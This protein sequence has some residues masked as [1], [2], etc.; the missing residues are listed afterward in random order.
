M[1]IVQ[2][3]R[4]FYYDKGSRVRSAGGHCFIHCVCMS[5]GVWEAWSFRCGGHSFELKEDGTKK[6]GML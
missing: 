4:V 5:T 6:N 3:E 2:L 1:S